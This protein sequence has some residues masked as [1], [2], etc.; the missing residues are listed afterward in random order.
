VLDYDFGGFRPPVVNPPA[1]NRPNAGSAVPIKF[2]LGG[3]FGLEVFFGAPRVFTCADWPT[4]ASVAAAG[5]P[6]TYNASSEVYTF[7]WKTLKSW[8]NTCR[9][10]EVTFDD[11]S[12]NTADF[13]FR[14]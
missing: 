5:D 9:T 10:L 14:Q 12:Y 7:A 1:V 13:D 3:D 8:A 2:R 6:L 11:G 4:G